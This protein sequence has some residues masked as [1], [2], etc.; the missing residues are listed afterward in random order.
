[1]ENDDIINLCEFCR[2]MNFRSGKCKQD[3]KYIACD[4]RPAKKGAC[5]GYYPRNKTSPPI[6]W[7]TARLVIKLSPDFKVDIRPPEGFDALSRCRRRF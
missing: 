1:M 2:S 7:A 5:K 3:P 6:S 4:G